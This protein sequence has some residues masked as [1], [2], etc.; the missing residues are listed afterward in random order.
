[1]VVGR[2]VVEERAEVAEGKVEKVLKEEVVTGM[3][4]MA[5]VVKV[6]C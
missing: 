3:E 5:E 6:L 1:M 4:K 2:E